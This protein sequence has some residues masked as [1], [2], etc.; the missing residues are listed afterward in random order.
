M[1]TPAPRPGLKQRLFP[2]TPFNGLVEFRNGPDGLKKATYRNVGRGGICLE[3]P[4]MLKPGNPI[5]LDFGRWLGEVPEA[6]CL[7]RVVWAEP[8]DHGCVVGVRIYHDE[9]SVGETLSALV[10]QVVTQN[11]GS[12]GSQP[13]LWEAMTPYA[14]HPGHPGAGVEMLSEG[15]GAAVPA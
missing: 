15:V 9:P 14:M 13:P 4:E 2:R 10:Q 1:K 6:E 7:A 8:T 5:L 12:V 11:D 3:S